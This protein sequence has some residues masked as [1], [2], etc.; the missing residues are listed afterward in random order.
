MA[1]VPLRE[2]YGHG[3]RASARVRRTS[4]RGRRGVGA[5]TPRGQ[6]WRQWRRRAYAGRR[7]MDATASVSLRRASRH[8]RRRV[9]ART[10]RGQAR[11]PW[12]RRAHAGRR[13]TDAVG[14]VHER[15]A[16]GH[17]RHG[18]SARTPGVGLAMRRVASRPSLGAA[19][20]PKKIWG[21]NASTSFS[22]REIGPSRGKS[23]PRRILPHRGSGRAGMPAPGPPVRERR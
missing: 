17:G 3:R 7:G 4:T 12:R 18:T 15:R 22:I 9:G 8:A 5:R 16:D 1:S 10:P 14:W 6:A 23:G 13:G 19:H 20:R 21:P 2:A 11:R